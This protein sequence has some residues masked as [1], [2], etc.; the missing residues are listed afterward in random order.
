MTCS[1]ADPQAYS[2][3]PF[4]LTLNTSTVLIPSGG[5]MLIVMKMILSL[6]GKCRKDTFDD[7]DI[8]LTASSK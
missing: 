2:R 3:G 8:G 4:D 1:H 7:N 5:L 6:N